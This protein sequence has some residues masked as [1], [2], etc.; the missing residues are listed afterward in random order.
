MPGAHQGQTEVKLQAVW[1]LRLTAV[2]EEQV[3]QLMIRAVEEEEPAAQT[4]QD[5][6]EEMV[7]VRHWVIMAAEAEALRVEA[8]RVRQAAQTVEQED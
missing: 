1:E 5:L 6:S 2:T 8:Q 7:I 3:T 4:G